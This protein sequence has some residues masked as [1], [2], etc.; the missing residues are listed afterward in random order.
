[1]KKIAFGIALAVTTV[2]GT[3]ALLPHNAAAQGR[4]LPT[5]EVDKTWPKVPAGMKVGDPSS[6]AI[7]AQGDAWVLNRP[8]TLKGDDKNHAAPP[9]MIFDP[10]GNYIRGWGGDGQGYQWPE[11][12][13]GITIDYKGFVWLGGNS[14]PTNG[15]PGLRPVADDQL[16]KFTQDGKFVMQIGHSNQSKGNADT[17]NLH[18]PADVQIDPSTDELYV[19]DGYGNHRVAVF[20]ANNG[21]FKRMWGAFGNKPVDADSC[22]IISYKDF[23]EPGRPQFSVVHAIRVAKDGMVYVADREN[24]RVQMFDRN[25]KFIK[26]IMKGDEIF[27]RNLAF[28][29]DAEQQ[30]LYTG[31]GKGIAVLDRKTLE[32]LGTIQP[33]GIL[34]A[35]HEIQSDTKGNL[36][37]AQ[38]GTG[39]Q[40]LLF[41]GM[42]KS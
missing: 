2:A 38:T 25:G 34:G 36:Y 28:S 1:V 18:R 22:A 24:R 29:P 15:L 7:D 12:E 19:A 32:Y 3:V 26:Q 30:F 6:I 17:V 27:A 13:H 20:D 5:F 8:R 14:C 16:L 42:S 37:I 11:R 10:N 40:R 9:I 35:G 41:K 23:A 33:P 39:M 4:S 31:Y 21:K